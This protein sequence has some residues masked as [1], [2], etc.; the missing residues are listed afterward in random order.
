MCMFF[1]FLCIISTKAQGESNFISVSSGALGFIF[2]MILLGIPLCFGAFYSYFQ[3]KS[4][5]YKNRNKLSTDDTEVYSEI[6]NNLDSKDIDIFLK[7][8]KK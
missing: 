6:L 5:L 8:K 4:L 3:L 1:F 7:Y 2:L